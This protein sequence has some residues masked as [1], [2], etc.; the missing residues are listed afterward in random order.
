MKVSARP[1][2]FARLG[3]IVRLGCMTQNHDDLAGRAGS[4]ASTPDAKSDAL[5]AWPLRAITLDLGSLYL[6]TNSLAVT[7]IAAVVT[8]V[9]YVVWASVARR[10]Q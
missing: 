1:D 10:H 3:M 6:V 4:P 2:G 7:A 5:A 9:V 8:V